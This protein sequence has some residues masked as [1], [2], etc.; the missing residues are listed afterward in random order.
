M[1]TNLASIL[2]RV[3][4]HFKDSPFGVIAVIILLCLPTFSACANRM[5]LNRA[6][7]LT[8]SMNVSSPVPPKGAT[9]DVS[10]IIDQLSSDPDTIRQLI[11]AANRK[12]PEG[13]KNWRLVKFYY[14]RGQAAKKL[15]YFRQSLLDFRKA[16]EYLP[17][18]PDK[19][20]T[21]AN[22]LLDLAA[23]EMNFNNYKNGIATIEKAR[24]IMPDWIG[25]NVFLV[26]TYAEFEELKRA[27]QVKKHT[28]TMGLK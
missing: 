17:K 10:V 2:T 4:K 27:E 24:S 8:S 19:N 3:M 22:L 16:S 13:A 15:G 7:D 6:N 21:T 18:Y 26:D 9:D 28:E 1:S 20:P 25:I 11:A 12:P 14:K 5:S 23:A